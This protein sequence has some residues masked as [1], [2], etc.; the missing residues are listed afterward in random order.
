MLINK[1]IGVVVFFEGEAVADKWL[2]VDNALADIINGREIVLVALHHRADQSQL[3]LAQ[4][5][6]AEGWVLGKDCHDHDV[7]AFL[8]GLH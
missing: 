3:M 8:D 5:K 1:L 2:E 4:I 7:A 6:H